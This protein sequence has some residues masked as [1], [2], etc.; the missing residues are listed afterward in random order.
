MV[1]ATIARSVTM[2]KLSFSYTDWFT[3]DDAATCSSVYPSGGDRT[4]A[5]VAIAVAAP[6]R[7]STTNCCFNR[8]DSACAGIRADKS[9]RPPGGKPTSIFTGLL[10]YACAHPVRDTNGS[11]AALAARCKKLRRGSHGIPSPNADDHRPA[12][13]K[14]SGLATGVV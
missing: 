9:A 8:S 10:G 1:P 2:L 4:T 6:G 14:P 5:S 3:E 13:P 11:A 7:F 12:R